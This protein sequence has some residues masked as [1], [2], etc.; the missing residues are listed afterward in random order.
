MARHLGVRYRRAE[1]RPPSPAAAV[2]LNA[3]AI[4]ALPEPLRA[5]LRS[6]LLSLDRKRI[7]Q[8]IQT[9]MEFE[10]TL[11][12]ALKACAARYAFTAMLHALDGDTEETV[13]TDDQRS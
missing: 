9:V 11:G 7:S 12:S 4:A 1:T 8:T 6:A 10:P 3:E 13:S 5:D 2:T